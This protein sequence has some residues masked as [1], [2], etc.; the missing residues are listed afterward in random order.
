MEPAT[1]LTVPFYSSLTG[2]SINHGSELDASYWSRNL[3]S[4]VL[5]SSAIQAIIE[6]STSPKIFLEIGPH[7]ALAGPIRQIVRAAVPTRKDEYIPTL[8]RGMSGIISVMKTVGELWLNNITP[9]FESINGRGE[10]L[11]D[12]PLYPWHYEEALWAE[13]RLSSEWRFRQ[14]AHH[15]VLG[16]RVL[17]TTTTNV[18][19]RNML[20]LDSVPWIKQHEV[21]G[22]ILFP[23]VGYIGM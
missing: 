21:A 20:R 7:S 12:L 17:E 9:N 1:I 10:F 5:F 19:W 8:V 22:D 4:P 23:G 18:A 14:H 15:D 6:K 3:K 11:V 2:A 13:S 16:S